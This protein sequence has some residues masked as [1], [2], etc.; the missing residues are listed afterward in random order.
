MALGDRAELKL[1]VV[2]GRKG[3]SLC[4]GRVGILGILEAWK[5]GVE[6]WPAMLPAQLPSVL[7]CLSSKDYEVKYSL[8]RNTR[9]LL[10]VP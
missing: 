6:L 1:A 9:V 4:W 3:V 10:I 2:I 7:G 8:V 5:I